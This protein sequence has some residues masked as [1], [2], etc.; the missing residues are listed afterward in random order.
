M[1][2]E[3]LPRSSSAT[4]RPGTPTIWDQ[5]RVLGE[6]YSGADDQIALATERRDSLDDILIKMDTLEKQQ[7]LPV[8]EKHEV[9]IE[10][11]DKEK[12]EE[13]EDQEEERKEDEEE[14]KEEEEEEKAETGKGLENEKDTTTLGDE[15]GLAEEKTE[16]DVKKEKEVKEGKIKLEENIK[17]GI[18]ILPKIEKDE[19]QGKLATKKVEVFKKQYLEKQQKLPSI[20][21]LDI[22]KCTRQHPSSSTL[23]KTKK[24]VP[25]L[26]RIEKA[27]KNTLK[28]DEKDVFV[29]VKGRRVFDEHER[30]T[31]LFS[32]RRENKQKEERILPKQKQQK[33]EL[34]EKKRTELK[35]E[36]NTQPKIKYKFFYSSRDLMGDT[37]SMPGGSLGLFYVGPVYIV[38]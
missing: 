26:D 25:R 18:E 13:I 3:E 34:N 9:I 32:L 24:E 5:F 27:T 35:K 10:E 16:G 37:G 38:L 4:S 7:I 33:I 6:Q 29:L 2:E 22:K 1:E 17:K 36:E 31:P 23:I 12:D 30:K 15:T 19:E 8:V 21:P 14:R 20:P 11:L 28:K